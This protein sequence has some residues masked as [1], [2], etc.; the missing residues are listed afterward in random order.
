MV[1]FNIFLIV[2]TNKNVFISRLDPYGRLKSTDSLMTLNDPKK[3]IT[4]KQKR[5]STYFLLRKYSNLFRKRYKV[6]S[7][8]LILKGAFSIRRKKSLSSAVIHSGLKVVVVDIT[9]VPFNGCRLKRKK[10]R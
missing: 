5:F 8:A 4:K 10:R 1:G 9:N 2:Q 3:N 7:V 6:S